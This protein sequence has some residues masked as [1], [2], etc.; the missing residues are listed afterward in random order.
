MCLLFHTSC[1]LFH[2]LPYGWLLYLSFSPSVIITPISLPQYIQLHYLINSSHQ[3]DLMSGSVSSSFKCVYFVLLFFKLRFHTHFFLSLASFYSLFPRLVPCFSL[4]NL[5]NATL[6]K[7]DFPWV[8]NLN[9]SFPVIHSPVNLC[10]SFTLLTP[11]VYLFN[12]L[13]DNYLFHDKN[14]ANQTRNV[15]RG[16]VP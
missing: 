5:L 3:N 16:Q 7:C 8:L 11:F 12:Y 9:E 15:L 4:D 13:I 2:H 14:K 1:P 10:F 6:L